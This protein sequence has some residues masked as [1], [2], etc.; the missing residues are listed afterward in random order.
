MNDF[1]EQALQNSSQA[2]ETY[3]ML[4][5]QKRA[6]FLDTIADE[7]EAI[8][9]PLLEVAAAESNLP[10]ARFKGERGRTCGQLRMFA[11]LLREGSWCEATIDKALPDRT[12][13]PRVDL[14]RMLIPI[15]PVAVF[16]ASNFPLAFS[17]A[18]G[19]T[20]SALAAGC[21]VVYK[22]HPAHPN[23]SK[24]VAE[25][26]ER[27]IQK[28]NLPIGVFQHI[29]GGIETGRELVLHPDIKAVAF[30]GSYAG[31]K[32]IFDAASS[33]PIPIP[34]FAEMGSINPIFI[35]PKKIE[36][37]QEE[38]AKQIASSVSLGVGQFCTN[39]G[40]ILIPK[41]SSND[42]LLS[43]KS[44]FEKLEPAPMLH[45]EIADNYRK[46]LD[47]QMA[48][49]GVSMI[50]LHQNGDTITGAPAIA[51]V[52]AEAWLKNPQLHEEVFG[53]FTLAVVYDNEE[54]L[55]KIAP[56]LQGQL[57]CSIW[58]MEDE[59]IANAQL[60][61]ILR[62][63]CGRLLFAGAPTGVE[64]SHAMTHGGPF[65]STTDSRSTSVGT[66]AIKRFARPVTW[67]SCPQELLPEE[68]K[69][70]NSLGIWRTID[71]NLSKEDI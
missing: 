16:G 57:T 41:A 6:A 3:K 71:G 67:Q 69:N 25:A 27:A 46:K 19:D 68:L 45:Q 32:S 35:L 40:L 42:F 11:K 50:Y 29:S 59:L 55:L 15:G 26:I 7:I 12:P 4:S 53:P 9:D 2:F 65:P 21:P 54:Q 30:T 48:Q 14:R 38:L 70:N 17:T 37:E 5:G 43:L 39:P 20:A 66:Y 28:H 13:M 49:K 64:V 34:V 22:E 24:M 58:A 33:R 31:G 18:G 52:D 36:Q 56:H 62:E 63:K 23:T 44:A 8:G 1:I 60:A 61:S 47:L 10:L 51:T